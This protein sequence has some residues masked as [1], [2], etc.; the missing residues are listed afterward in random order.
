MSDR[1]LGVDRQPLAGSY[2]ERRREYA[3]T[4]SLGDRLADAVIHGVLLLILVLTVVPFYYML[5]VSFARYQDVAGGAFY[6]IPRH[7]DLASYALIFED[8][9]IPRA[10]LVSTVVTIV[11]TAVSMLVTTSAAYALSKK[12]L[13]GRNAIFTYIIITMFFSGGLIPLYLVM[14]DLGFVDSYLVMILPLAV[15]TFF[16][17]LMKNYFLTIPESL[18]ESAKIDGANDILIMFRIVIPIAAPIMAT[19]SLFYAVTFWNDWWFPDALPAGSRQVSAAAPAAQD[20]HRAGDGE[21]ARPRVDDVWQNV[22]P[23]V[24]ADGHGRD[25]DPAYP[26]RVSLCAEVLCQGNHDR[27]DQGM[28]SDLI[29]AHAR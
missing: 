1:L 15:N 11:G 24:R 10:F 18:E 8:D 29:R 9:T 4:R 5:V 28:N 26:P 7:I 25:R 17:I 14:Q 21:P 6:L 19:I 27:C 12:G 22:L 3:R 2:R 13:P 16:L 23:A 20:R